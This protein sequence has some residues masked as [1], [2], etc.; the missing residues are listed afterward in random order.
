MEATSLEHQI[1]GS[2]P[3]R[4]KLQERRHHPPK[5]L[6]ADHVLRDSY[7][8][9]PCPG[10]PQSAPSD[11][12]SAF[13]PAAIRPAH[14]VA[15]SV[16][17]VATHLVLKAALLLPLHLRCHI[18]PLIAMYPNLSLRP[19]ALLMRSPLPQ[20]FGLL[21]S[22]L[23]YCRRS[24]GALSNHSAPMVIL[25]GD[26][27][28]YSLQP[29]HSVDTTSRLLLPCGSRPT[30]A[31]VH[32]LHCQRR[33]VAPSTRVLSHHLVDVLDCSNST[34]GC[35]LYSCCR[36]SISTSLVIATSSALRA[37]CSISTSIAPL[38]PRAET[39]PEP[40]PTR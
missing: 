40:S 32:S 9:R 8:C 37:A 24:I 39:L 28:V 22:S 34:P 14:E 25:L 13:A 33:Y 4:V 26:A 23:S 6:M 18:G 3:F 21:L 38:M 17:P 31:L 27:L 2:S 1:G 36:S 15:H 19:P 35:P 30:G 16:V 5:R 10:S 11:S 29:R 12:R 7:C 20:H